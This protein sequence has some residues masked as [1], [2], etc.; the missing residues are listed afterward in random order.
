MWMYDP[1]K[2]EFWLG[3]LEGHQIYVGETTW[4]SEG[5]EENHG[6]GFYKHSKKY[7]ELTLHGPHRIETL[8]LD[9]KKRP[10]FQANIYRWPAGKFVQLIPIKKPALTAPCADPVATLTKGTANR[11]PIGSEPFPPPPSYANSRP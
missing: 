8:L 1:A 3:R 7:K 5:G 6:G 11:S 4:Y 2:K 9:L 10:A